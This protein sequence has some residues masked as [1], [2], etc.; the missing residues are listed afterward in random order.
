MSK[1]SAVRTLSTKTLGVNDRVYAKIMLILG[2]SS[3]LLSNVVLFVIT[4]PLLLNN[5]KSASVLGR[6]DS[7]LQGTRLLLYS[8]CAIRVSF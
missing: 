1:V 5:N 3:H 2:S 7:T 8:Y 6:P 4:S